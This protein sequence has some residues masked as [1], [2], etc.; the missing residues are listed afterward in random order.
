MTIKLPAKKQLI[1][2]LVAAFLGLLGGFLGKDLSGLQKP[3]ENAAEVVIDEADVKITP[4][5]EKKIEALMAT[6]T[7][8]VDAGPETAAPSK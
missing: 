2:H 5:A 6:E 3:V 1:S 8:S 4:K 7:K